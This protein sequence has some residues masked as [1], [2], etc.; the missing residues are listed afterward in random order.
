MRRGVALLSVAFV[1]LAAAAPADSALPSAA[2]PAKT[3]VVQMR[4]D[5]F[6]PATVQI[7]PGDSVRWVNAGRNPHDVVASDG[8][9]QSKILQTGESF[10]VTFP[11][12]GSFAYY[13]HLHGAS[14]TGMNGRVYVGVT[15]EYAGS[16][17]ASRTYPPDPPV[18]PSGGKTIH[19]PRDKVT[20]QAAVDA[21]SPGDMILIA[22]GVYHEAVIVTTPHLVLRGE[23]R[24]RVILDGEFDPDY[25]NGIAVFG[26]DGVVIENMTAR[27]YRLNGFYWRSVWGYRGSYLTADA[28]GDY[29]IYA[30]DSGVGQFDH[31]YASGSPDSGFYIGQ[32]DPCNALITDVIARNN[33]LGFSGT[34]A[35]R[36]LVI[37]DSE[38]A[39][40]MAGIVPN[41]LDRE[42]LA[43]Q[44]SATIV[45]NWV[46]DNNNRDAP[47]KADEF[48]FF[49]TGIAIVGGREDEVAYNRV[50]HHDNM[51]ILVS[52]VIDENIWL[53]GADRVHDNVVADSGIADLAL[54]A[55]AGGGNCFEANA[56][57]SALPPLIE[58][59]YACGSPLAAIGG[60]DV[61]L[62]LG[63]L[64]RLFRA[65]NLDRYPHG[66]VRTAPAA[67]PQPGMTDI[68]APAAPAGP[69]RRVDP[70]AE[71][72]AAAS[73]RA[74]TAA[75]R[76]PTLATV[77]Y[78]LAGY[79]LPL[80]F[81]VLVAYALV[82]RRRR[83]PV[84][85]RRYLFA[86]LGVYVAF[87]ACVTLVELLRP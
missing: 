9:F 65:V 56:A 46:H 41:T 18:R 19:V 78:T 23:D 45:D 27:H 14:G 62:T 4:D 31:S 74:A 33:A 67:P 15:P 10:T 58:T 55:P 7:D 57:G 39:D 50:E 29:G 52:F 77:I 25:A 13:C 22:P 30:F 79:L 86:P 34:N 43:P 59:F 76:G 2:A 11:K 20:I 54:I 61:A 21:A 48:P 72:R 71:V 16:T 40:N 82:Q 64:G 66:D 24:N 1:V 81:L 8:S 6:D 5:F 37:R 68:T 49:G 38:F 63:G 84:P 12:I 32:C 73:G 69:A 26:A 44:W 80:A 35:S 28:N 60:G 3:V 51:G 87:L 53:A 70:A 42:A 47:A 75:W 36:N 85:R 83:R 17:S